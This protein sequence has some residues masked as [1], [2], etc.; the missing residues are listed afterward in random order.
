MSLPYRITSAVDI[1]LTASGSIKHNAPVEYLHTDDSILAD[2]KG[3]KSTLNEDDLLQWNGTNLSS[4]SLT[5]LTAL[6]PPGA[7]IGLTPAFKLA[8]G[9][10]TSSETVSQVPGTYNYSFTGFSSVGSG[11]LFDSADSSF[12]NHTLSYQI[13]SVV[14]TDLGIG[15]SLGNTDTTPVSEGDGVAYIYQRRMYIYM[16]RNT[17][18]AP[19]VY[20]IFFSADGR[21]VYRMD[22]S[23]AAGD[24]LTYVI[25]FDRVHVYQNGSLKGTFMY[26]SVLSSSRFAFQGM[27]YTD[28][29]DAVYWTYPPEVSLTCRLFVTIP[30]NMPNFTI[31]N[32]I[33]LPC[34]L[35]APGATGATGPQGP[36]GAD[37]DL[38]N[39]HITS[40]LT[41]EGNVT[42][43]YEQKQVLYSEATFGNLAETVMTI[44]LETNQMVHVEVKSAI[45][46][47]TK[48]GLVR[49]ESIYYEDGGSVYRVTN[50]DSSNVLSSAEAGA[51]VLQI[52]DSTILVKHYAPSETLK[53]CSVVTITKFQL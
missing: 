50:T 20:P 5:D 30:A 15:F 24:T 19:D 42:D 52:A 26:R 37:A 22:L 14:A 36:A 27:S 53:I 38:D 23:A 11:K 33:L 12:V 16:S 45:K 8:T 32:L 3:L 29:R 4:I 51:I 39:A 31:P 35:G 48:S 28:T 43:S 6:I 9:Y 13:P 10:T 1:L 17:L 47:A 21:V 7:A 40:S 49:K 34:V 41:L 25:L 46:S 18:D 44:T 2:L